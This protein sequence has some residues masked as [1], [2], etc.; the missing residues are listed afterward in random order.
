[1]HRKKSGS[2]CDAASHPGT[3]SFEQHFN[4]NEQEALMLMRR[5]LYFTLPDIKSARG[6]LPADLPEANVL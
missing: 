1:L 6:M 5:R 4:R 3:L 2:Q